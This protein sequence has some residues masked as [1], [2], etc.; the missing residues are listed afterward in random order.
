ME[1]IIKRKLTNNNIRLYLSFRKLFLFLKD[2]IINDIRIKKEDI[3]I[4]DGISIIPTL[5]KFSL[6]F[7]LVNK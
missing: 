4:A 6:I 3:E 2:S 5:K 7:T 1:L